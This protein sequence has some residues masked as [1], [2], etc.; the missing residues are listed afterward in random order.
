MIIHTWINKL[1]T[2]EQQLCPHTVLIAGKPR[3]N[4]P[5][6]RRFKDE[7]K[8]KTKKTHSLRAARERQRLWVYSRVFFTRFRRRCV[9]WGMKKTHFHPR[10]APS[11]RQVRSPL[12]RTRKNVHLRRLPRARL[13]CCF[14]APFN[15]PRAFFFLS[16]NKQD[17]TR[18]KQT[19]NYY[20]KKTEV[21]RFFPHA[22]RWQ[23]LHPDAG[24]QGRGRLSN[25]ATPPHETWFLFFFF[26]KKKRTC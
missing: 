12:P 2:S 8:N 4:S 13:A 1:K 9:F 15:S 5:N 16:S 11:H 23:P 3:K 25:A 19:N 17:K 6:L 14:S 26:K 22:S 18:S 24:K 7:P 20:F 21:V 10:R